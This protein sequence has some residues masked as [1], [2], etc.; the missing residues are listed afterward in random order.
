MGF[1]MDGKW[2]PDANEIAAGEY[3]D[4]SYAVYA[5]YSVI[6]NEQATLLRECRL[7]IDA[8][9]DQK[10]MLGAM[11]CGS[12]TLGNLRVDLHAIRPKDVFGG[13]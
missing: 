8:L 11:L 10:P 4:M 7:A 1:Y 3:T 12:T 6:I 2:Q 5:G 13:N 9:L